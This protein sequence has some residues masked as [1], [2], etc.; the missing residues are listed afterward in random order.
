MFSLTLSVAEI[1]EK[2]KVLTNYNF[3]PVVL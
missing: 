2:L 1:L 3:D